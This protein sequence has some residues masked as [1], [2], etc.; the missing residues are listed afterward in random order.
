MTETEVEQWSPIF[1]AD[2]LVPFAVTWRLLRGGRLVAHLVDEAAGK[3]GL[4][5]AGDFEVLAALRRLHPKPGQAAALSAATMTSPSGMTGRLDRLEAQGLLARKA[6]LADRRAVDVTLT[7]SGRTLAEAVF[8]SALEAFSASL[9]SLTD[10]E[11][12]AAARLL[13]GLL[14]SLGDVSGSHEADIG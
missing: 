8:R 11:L 14:M 4:P 9:S 1:E 10:A 6:N 13:A 2:D 7:E 12:R 5:I 3:H